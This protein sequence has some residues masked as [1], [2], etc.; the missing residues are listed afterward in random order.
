MGFH[1]IPCFI[2]KA[3]LA[4]ASS[5]LNMLTTHSPPTFDVRFNIP[6]SLSVFLAGNETQHMQ[7]HSA[8]DHNWAH[9]YIGSYLG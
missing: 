5:E 3:H 7:H 6:P 9:G 2:S 4:K 8:L 1:Q